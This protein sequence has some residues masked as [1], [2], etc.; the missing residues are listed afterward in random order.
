M[1]FFSRKKTQKLVVDNEVYDENDYEPI[2]QKV[3]GWLW[4]F[5]KLGIVI[6]II[7]GILLTGII[8]G[9]VRSFS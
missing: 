6:T 3:I 2:T 9:L 5:F 1:K 8:F 7:S 4:F